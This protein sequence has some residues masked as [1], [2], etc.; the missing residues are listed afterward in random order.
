MIVLH[1]VWFLI[2]VI[3][4]LQHLTM[5]PRLACCWSKAPSYLFSRLFSKCLSLK[6]CI[7]FKWCPPL[8][9]SGILLSFLSSVLVSAMVVKKW[10]RKEITLL[11]KKRANA[12]N[13]QP[14]FWFIE[15]FWYTATPVF[16]EAFRLRNWKMKRE[17]WWETGSKFGLASMTPK[18]AV[19]HVLLIKHTGMPN[20]HV[21]LI[22]TVM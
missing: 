1:K 12:I 17:R 5:S 21:V 13:H 15:A 4:Y 10:Q 3:S 14:F 18:A 9:W 22:L 8:S 2:M 11:C 6:P 19:L 16:I 7:V 20:V